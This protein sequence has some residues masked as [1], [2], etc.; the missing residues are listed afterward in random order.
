MGELRHHLHQ[1]KGYPVQSFVETGTYMG[2]GLA[3]A[4]KELPGLARYYSIEANPG[5]QAAAAERFG[6]LVVLLGGDSAQVIPELVRAGW[7]QQRPALWWL[8]AHFPAHYNED[9][10][11]TPLPLR[12]ELEAIV[13]AGGHERDVFLIDDWRVWEPTCAPPLPAGARGVFLAPEGE[14]AH[15]KSLLTPTHFLRLSQGPREQGVL[16]AVPRRPCAT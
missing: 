3:T 11:A 9:V 7:P 5:F 4:L 10:G 8:D 13:E 2:A 1:V 6:D 12:H 15:L 14:G 16:V